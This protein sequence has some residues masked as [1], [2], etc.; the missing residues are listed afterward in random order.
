MSDSA[1]TT[2]SVDARLVAPGRAEA[3][4][5]HATI[6]FDTA[7][8][9]GD[10]LPGPAELP[11]TAFAACLLKN[12]ERFSA[13][14]PFAQEGARV[15]VSATRQSSPPRFTGI[16]YDLR[17]VTDEPQARVDLLHRNLRRHGTVYNT[18]AAV[19]EVAGTITAER[20]APR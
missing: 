16:D 17:V 18:F 7:P 1:H 4:A 20:H 11:A 6:A 12:V 2:Y 15:H 9:G 10:E 3:E 5:K 13:T 19:C 8:A 14:L